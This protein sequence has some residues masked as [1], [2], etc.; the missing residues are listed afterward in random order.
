MTINS[1]FNIAGLYAYDRRSTLRWVFSHVWRYKGLTGLGMVLTVGSIAGY[2]LSPVLIGLAAQELQQPGGGRLL[3]YALA[4]LAVLMGDGVCNLFAYYCFENVAKRFQ[5]DAR[6]ELYAALLGKSQTFHSRQRTGDIMAR[7]TD[8]TGLLSEM[9]VPGASLIYETVLS[10]LIPFLFIGLTN[11]R[12]LLVPLL[13]LVAYVFAVRGY[14]RQLLPVAARQREQFGHMN[15]ALEE[16]VSGIELVKASSREDFERNKFRGNARGIRDSFVEQGAIEA[17]YLPLLL[18][19]VTIALTFLHSLWLYQN[20]QATLAEIIGVMGLV[21][22]LRFPTYISIFTFSLVQAGLASSARILKIIDEETELDE[23]SGGHTAPVRGELVFENVSFG[24]ADRPLLHGVSLRAA[25][26]QTIAIVGQTGSGKSSLAQLVNRTYDASAG[27]VLV[28][29]VDVRDWSLAALR[30]QI[31]KIEQDIFLFSRTIAENIA[32][33]KPQA[34]RA[35]IEEAARAAQAHD[36]ICGQKDGYDTVVGERGVTLSGGQRQRIALARAFLSNPRILI[37]DDA[38]S[39]IDSATEDDI[40]R[41]LRRV[42]HGR[43]TILITHRL[44]QIRWADTIVVLDKGRVVA[45][46]AHAEL[47]RSSV[48]YR[49]IFSRFDAALPPADPALAAA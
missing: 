1:E 4:T 47:L 7:A 46:G 30:S 49:R 37:L 28:D 8:D 13:F 18:F 24:F 32:F 23:N 35:E 17:R 29:G 19:G 11:W 39:A 44:A 31:G 43:T 40:Q 5:A 3:W 15:A 22:V 27:R 33:G 20:G 34:A 38:T 42:Q 26:G 2:S 48:H 21:N 45:V 14:T 36:F 6:H 16:T 25:A 41:A 12:L 10:I 9:L